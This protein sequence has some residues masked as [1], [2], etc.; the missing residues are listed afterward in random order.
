M[1]MFCERMKKTHTIL[2]WASF[3]ASAV[4]LLAA[5]LL[6]VMIGLAAKLGNVDALFK[7]TCVFVKYAFPLGVAFAIPAV[8]L[9]VILRSRIISSVVALLL[10]A[11]VVGAWWIVGNIPV[12]F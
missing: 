7:W 3:T 2:I 10:G 8:V 11:V 1:H 5:G 4:L 9:A 6:V 12:G